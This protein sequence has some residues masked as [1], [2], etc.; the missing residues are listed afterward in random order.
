M[1]IFCIGR[2]YAD[3]AKE[4]NSKIPDQP[5]IFMKP[6]TAIC[7]TSEIPYPDFTSDLHYELEVLL[8]ISKPGSRITLED[9]KSY[10]EAIGLG[11][12]FTA[13]DIQRVCKQKG[14][15][16]ERA[17][18]FDNSAVISEKI[19]LEKYNIDQMDFSLFL[20]DNR[21]QHGNTKDLIFKFNVLI[22]EISK[23]FSLDT[24]DV[25]FTGTPAGVGPVKPGDKLSAFIEDDLY[26]NLS[27][28]K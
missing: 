27:I 17:K 24:G 8:F 13:S 25:I 20:N 22:C 7:A 1:K 19:P 2:N 23:Y 15:P 5:M 16:W 21:V 4:M 10:Y 3:H 12:D 28:I 9:A 11:I 26:L 18:S 6:D 14:H